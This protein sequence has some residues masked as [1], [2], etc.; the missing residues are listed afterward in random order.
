MKIKIKLKFKIK[1]V[2]AVA[3]SYCQVIYNFKPSLADFSG[4]SHGICSNCYKSL[5]E[6]VQK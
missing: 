1:G 2:L 4:I 3:C 5:T 6:G